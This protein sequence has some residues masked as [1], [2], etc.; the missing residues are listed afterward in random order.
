[1]LSRVVGHNYMPVYNA[2]AYGINITNIGMRVMG[3][4][5]LQFAHLPDS[6]GRRLGTGLQATDKQPEFV[7]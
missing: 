3:N 1:M 6:L 4:H 5:G 7:L 2:S